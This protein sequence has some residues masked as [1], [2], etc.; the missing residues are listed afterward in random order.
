V[1]ALLKDPVDPF[2]GLQRDDDHGGVL[3]RAVKPMS[4][5]PPRGS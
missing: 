5:F 1:F 3:L 4:D 2:R